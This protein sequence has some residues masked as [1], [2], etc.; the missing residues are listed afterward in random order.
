MVSRRFLVTPPFLTLSPL[1]AAL[2]GRAGTAR[3]AWEVWLLVTDKAW[4]GKKSR[5]GEIIMTFVTF[6]GLNPS[7][8]QGSAVY[9]EEAHLAGQ[10][11]IL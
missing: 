1:I 4:Q 8:V 11:R 10:P 3:K 2:P 6:S 5:G 7:A 9:V